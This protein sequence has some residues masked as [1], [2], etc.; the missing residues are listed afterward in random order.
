M[1][2]DLNAARQAG[3]S[4]DEIINHLAQ[5]RN[6]DIAGALRAGYTKQ[7]I[8][9]YLTST[10]APGAGAGGPQF[11]ENGLPLA[12]EA[13]ITYTGPVMSSNE[14]P[15][16]MHGVKEGTVDAI[17]GIRAMVDRNAKQYGYLGGALKTYWDMAK[18]LILM[19]PESAAKLREAIQNRDFGQFLKYSPALLGGIGEGA[20][21]AAEPLKDG[22]VGQA[23]GRSAAFIGGSVLPAKVHPVQWARSGARSVARRA[24]NAMV[25]PNAEVAAAV[26]WGLDEGVPVDAATATGNRAVSAAQHLSDRTIG[27]SLV[28]SEARQAQARGLTAAGERLAGRVHPTAVSPEQA[29]TAVVSRL[30]QNV[31]AANKSADAA[32][33]ALRGIEKQNTRTVQVGTRTVDTGVLDANGRPVTH[34]VPITKEVG[35]P[36]DM[37]PVKKALRPI[38]ERMK[39]RMP[40]AQQ[41]ASPGLKAIENIL[42]GDD[43]VSASVADANLGAVKSIV[44]KA[45]SADLRDVSQGTAAFAVKR[46]D[47]AVT[48]AV[49]AGGKDAVDALKAGRAATRGKYSTAELLNQLRDEPVQVFNQATWAKDAGLE[50]LRALQR[51]AP[52]EMAKLGRAYLDDLLTRATAEGEFSRTQGIWSRWQN[53]GPE[54]KKIIFGDQALVKDLDNFFLLAKK[55]SESPNPSGT[56]HVAHLAAHGALVISHPLT[57][58]PLQIGSNLLSRM[59]HNPKFVRAIT[60]G[61]KTPTS[62]RQA[63]MFQHGKIMSLVNG[64]KNKFG[65]LVKDEGGFLEIGPADK[66]AASAPLRGNTE[67]FA[68][69]K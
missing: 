60:S 7:D 41:Q 6:F 29:G 4:D 3:Y 59:L 66:A 49:A 21:W 65:K 43:I 12:S 56:A 20:I 38:Y 31:S 42:D 37:K 18:G 26:R 30:E 22:H 55:M 58:I 2:F 15:G 45:Q 23:I 40:L 8:M 34:E 1:A 10:P 24:A 52:Q 61:M 39:E 50:R 53:L 67:P 51:E 64:M 28:E 19:T 54:T 25:N 44:R 14:D 33:G 36:V 46:L 57:G 48:K 27:G 69:G 5:T 47:A 9:Q 13:N 35:L 63:A 17:R 32:Y 16:V 62:N 68:G 11:D